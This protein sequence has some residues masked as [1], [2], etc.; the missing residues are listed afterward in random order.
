MLRA[1][2]AFG[3][4]TVYAGENDA[5]LYN[6]KT[7]RA[8][9]GSLFRVRVQRTADLTSDIARLRQNGF[10]IFATALD[11]HSKDIRQTDL[12][13]KIGFVIGNEGHGI[14]DAVRAACSGSV[15]IPMKQG[16]QSLNAAMAAGIVM[17]EAARGRGAGFTAL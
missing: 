12:S 1:A 16:P 6:P 14:S 11:E 10:R 2:D 7:V 5:D 9:M 4:D 3:V 17:W 15:I 13:G 8:C